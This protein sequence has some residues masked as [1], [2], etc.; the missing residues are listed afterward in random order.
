MCSTNLALC[1][2][3]QTGSNLV[4]SSHALGDKSK[5]KSAFQ[6]LLEINIYP[7]GDDD[8]GDDEDDGQ[9]LQHDGLREELRQRQEDVHKCVHDLTPSS[10]TKAAVHRYCFQRSAVSVSS[11]RAATIAQSFCCTAMPAVAP[12]PQRS[13]RDLACLK[14]HA[15]FSADLSAPQGGASWLGQ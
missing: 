3:L 9:T 5:M 4:I 11:A 2:A 10:T 14:S 7:E 12:P 13:V 1:A 8:E 6:K 15:L